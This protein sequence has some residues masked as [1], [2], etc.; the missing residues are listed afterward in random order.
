LDLTLHLSN[1][2]IIASAGNAIP[3]AGA[4]GETVVADAAKVGNDIRF[5]IVSSGTLP[6]GTVA[7]FDVTPVAGLQPWQSTKLT[8]DPASTMVDAGN[9]KAAITKRANGTSDAVLVGGKWVFDLGQTSQ[10]AA[11]VATANNAETAYWGYDNGQLH[12]HKVADAS[13]GFGTVD[14]A[15][16]GVGAII[17]R[18]IFKDDRVYVSGTGGVA[19]VNATDGTV[20][21]N[22]ALPDGLTPSTSPAVDGNSVYVG[23]QQGVVV[24]LNGD[25]N[26]AV[27]ARSAPLGAAVSADPAVNGT[28]VW[29][30]AGNQVF[31]LDPNDAALKPLKALPVA[32]GPVMSPPFISPLIPGI[33]GAGAR[34]V[35]VGS[36]DGK[37]YLYD[38]TTVQLIATY[39]AGAPIVAASYID[40]PAGGNPSTVYVVTTTGDVHAISLVGFNPAQMGQT[41]T[42]RKIA[43]G[44]GPVNT[45]FL[46]VGDPRFGYTSAPDQMITNR[47]DLFTSRIIIGWDLEERK[48]YFNSQRNIILDFGGD[49]SFADDL[50]LETSLSLV[51]I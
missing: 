3:T 28:E 47:C 2:D 18:P 32:G 34:V 37:L 9:N 44:L 24:K 29:V 46:T 10:S 7:T 51:Y 50:N 25:N 42:G 36:S 43:A 15:N 33:D 17:R 45:A 1:P 5:T 21:W 22:V 11:S 48:R 26:G 40:W 14:V 13:A 35:A 20:I 4:N 12:A 19:K 39:D 49:K 6:N 38:T 23:T 31:S 16:A 27:L 8:I 30:A 41:L